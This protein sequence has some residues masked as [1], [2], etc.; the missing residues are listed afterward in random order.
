[1]ESL[2]PLLGVTRSA[3]YAW[4]TRQ[5]SKR[6][7]EDQAILRELIRLH[8]LYPAMGLDSL[9]HLVK[10]SIPCSRK[11]VWRL[12]KKAEIHSARKK[13]YKETTNSNHKHPIAPNILARDFNFSLP[14]QAWVSDITYIPTGEGW[15]YR[16]IIKDLCSKK[17]VGYAT[18]SRIDTQ[19][20]LNAL[21]MAVRRQR[22]PPGL[23]FHS[24]RGESTL[25]S[26]FE[27]PLTCM[28][29]GRVCHVR[30]I[31]TTTL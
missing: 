19:L 15:L 9:H 7:L 18:S 6:Q 17:I 12:M 14:N 16:T 13:A 1:V 3:Y 2:C 25:P 11:R 10:K 5:P 28:G 8:Q 30:A 4:K 23:I 26:P 29:S 22:P 27:A 31:L 20:T 24:D 21:D